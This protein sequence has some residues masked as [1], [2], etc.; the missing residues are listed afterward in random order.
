MPNMPNDKNSYGSIVKSIGLFGGVKFFQILVGI[1]KNK[2]VALIL[3][4]AGMGISGMIL[5]ATGMISSLTGIGLQT[6]SVIDIAKSHESN[7]PQEMSKTVTILRKLVLVTGMVGMIVTFIFAPQL[8][9]WSFGNY[10][11]TSAFRIV[12]VILLLDQ[13]CVG[14]TAL[15]QGTFHYR[16]LARS[17]FYSSLCGALL[18]VPIYY[19]WGINGIVPVI[20][21][22][23]AINLLFSWY[24]S[25]QI[26]IRNLSMSFKDVFKCGAPM[27]KLG[28][29]YA[30]TGSLGMIQVYLLRLF[31]ANTGSIEDVGLYTAGSVIA[32]QYINL[33][34]TSMGTDYSPRLA[35]LSSDRSGFVDAVNKQTKLL[36]IIVVPLLIPFVVF[37]KELTILL[38]SKSFL[39]IAVMIEW[40]MFGMFFRTISWCLSYTIAARGEAKRFLG[41]ETANLLYSLI[42]SVIGYKYLGFLGLGIGFAFTYFV[43]TIHMF[44]LCRYSYGF[45]YTQT[46]L[47][48]LSIMLLLFLLF[49][50]V[51]QVTSQSNLR[52]IIGSLSFIIISYVSYCEFNKMMPVKD[53]LKTIKNKIRKV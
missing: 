48:I 40:M 16:M 7:K 42:F 37:A 52:Y 6:S 27:I 12:S 11:Y 24:Y 2:I 39:P 45:K 31:I 36:I 15:L 51:I 10:N 23:S 14:Q 17:Q 34:L 49:F 9:F 1:V 26:S 35:A 30:L 13:I 33:I 18:C 28:L 46:T 29:A 19:I 43:Y 8:S 25:R 20:I 50:A 38:Y 44:L 5:T 41:N 3:G 32:T 22:T 47:Y 21:L 4:P 53:V